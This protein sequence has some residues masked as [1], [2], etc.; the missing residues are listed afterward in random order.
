[1]KHSIWIG[2]DPRERLAFDIARNSLL[3]RLSEPIPVHGLILPELRARGVYRRPTRIEYAPK[4]GNHILIDEL[5][6]TDTYNGAMSTE[7]ACARFWVPQ[8]AGEGWALFMDGDTLVRGDL[9]QVFNRLDPAKALYCVQHN[10]APADK[11]KK[12]QD[13]Q[14]RYARKN[15]SSFM[16]FNCEHP[17]NRWLDLDVLNTRPGRDLHAFFWL[18]DNE[19]GALDQKW[20]WL[21]GH[22]DPTIDPMVCHFT[23]GTPNLPGYENVPYADEWRIEAARVGWNSAAAE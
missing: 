3:A 10:Y 11:I 6:A 9:A 2:Y 15:W 22:S 1:M 12:D 5:S 16:I 4:H 8:L 7:H 23:E 18:N 21:V 20:N 17:S 14:T 19:I 13:Q